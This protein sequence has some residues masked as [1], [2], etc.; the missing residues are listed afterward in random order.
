MST[1]KVDNKTKMK[2]LLSYLGILQA[3]CGGLFS[4][5]VMAETAFSQSFETPQPSHCRYTYPEGTLPFYA[6]EFLGTRKMQVTQPGELG[7]VTIY[8]KNTG[9]APMFSDNSGCALR[10]VT[11]LGTARYR[12]R[13]SLLY[14]K[15]SD[16]DSGWQSPNRI[17]LDQARL[18]PGEEGSFTFWMKTPTEEGIYHE[19]FDVVIEGKKWLNNDFAVPFDVGKFVHEN[20]NYLSFILESRRVTQEE[21][22]GERN[23][24]VDISDQKMYLKIGD[25]VI[26]TFPVSTGTYRTPTPYGYTH[27][28]QKQEVRIGS[29]WPYYI[30]PKWMHFRAGGYGIHS[31]PSIRYGNGSY[32]REALNHIGT[33]R[34]HGCIRLL[35]ADAEFAYNFAPIG[36]AV[37]VHE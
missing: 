24:E 37:W 31:L 11:R 16:G 20:R 10:P 23:I 19:Y 4:S 32:W 12:D 25:I 26:R 5:T 8:I 14:T 29:K 28:F 30:M 3:L 1:S 21:L 7:R 18:N 35:P 27:I 34:S 17:K 22:I 13:E 2:K 9:T 6:Y 36:T 15:L 33:R